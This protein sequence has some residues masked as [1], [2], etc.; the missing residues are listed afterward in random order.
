[1]LSSILKSQ[2]A[3]EINI[4]IMRAFVEIRKMISL[5]SIVSNE[6]L[7]FKKEIEEKLGEYD[8]QL[9]EI[10][11]IMEQLL[12]KNKDNQNWVNRNKIGYKQ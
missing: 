7:T 4:A 11:T 6:I 12:E 1:M 2:K 10:Y 5:Q 3:V 9:L 8:V